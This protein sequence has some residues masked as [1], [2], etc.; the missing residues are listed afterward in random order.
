MIVVV[1]IILMLSAMLFPALEAA[2]GKAEGISCVSNLR[3]LGIAARLYADDY[4]GTIVPAMLPHDTR[5][6]ICW[7]AT[8]Q[9]YVN[10]PG[11][12]ICPSD[13]SPRRLRGALCVPHSYGINLELAEVGGYMG[14]S[15]KLTQVEDPIG[16]IL[17]AELNGAR[18]CTHGVRY[19]HNGLQVVATRRH[20]TGANYGFADGHARWLLPQA[21]EEPELLWDP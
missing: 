7:D 1:A 19:S 3:N 5:R 21:T 10:N 16:T 8:I 13:E 9:A 20:G 15:M 2:M 17:F 12:L 18:Y 11:L 14:S 6:R 4:D